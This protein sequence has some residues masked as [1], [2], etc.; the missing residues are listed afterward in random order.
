MGEVTIEFSHDSK[1]K[2]L[3]ILWRMPIGIDWKIVRINGTT[4]I[5]WQKIKITVKVHL[6]FEF[7]QIRAVFFHL[8]DS[9]ATYFLLGWKLIGY[10]LLDALS[11]FSDQF[12]KLFNYCEGFSAMQ[13][14]NW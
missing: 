3:H 6:L 9:S 4:H 11:K 10:D 14:K 7:K 12:A 1:V 2:R 5:Y 8:D 13:F